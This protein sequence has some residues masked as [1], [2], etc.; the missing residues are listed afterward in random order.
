MAHEYAAS[1]EAFEKATQIMCS[2][3]SIPCSDRYNSLY[4]ERDLHHALI[5]L[6][7][8]NGYAESGMG[9][10]AIEADGARVPSGS[11]VRDRVGSINEE[12]MAPMLDNALE[13]TLYQ[14]KSFRVFNSPIM[15]AIDTHD[16]PRYDSD[17][18]GGFL[19]RGKRERGTTKRESYAT[20][21]CVEDGKRAQI[22]CEQ[23]GFFDEKDE[24]V[25][26]LLNKAKLDGVEIFL[27]LLDRGFFSI[28]AINALKKNDQVFL[29]PCILNSGIKRAIIEHAERKRRRISEYT[30]GRDEEKRASFTLV[31]LPKAGA[32]N[33]ADPLKQFIPFATNMPRKRIVWNVGRLPRDYRARWGI[34]SGYN[35]VEQFRA[36]TTSRN[37]SLR[38]LYLYYALI[39]YNAW[40][41]ANLTIASK[42][43][44]VMRRPIIPVQIVKAVLHRVIVQSFGGG[45]SS[46]NAR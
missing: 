46:I 14:V 11:W 26:R 13:S 42:F 39:L 24:I 35:G 31:I 27:L 7:I 20:L 21:Q 5:S 30:M 18:D 19:R 3:V 28:A 36:R 15:A 8:S 12:R 38:L 22:A 45:S 16:I 2:K 43:S 40:L 37:H 32:E 9:R 10:L 17:L 33:E 44:K 41:I 23:F 4:D 6:S 29:M 25:E 1:K 34:E